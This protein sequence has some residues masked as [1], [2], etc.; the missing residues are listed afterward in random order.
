MVSSGSVTPDSSRPSTGGAGAATAS[1]AVPD[2]ARPRPAPT[3][4]SYSITVRLYARPD[5]TVVGR[6]ANTVSEANGMVTAVDVSE[7]RQD[8][9]TIDLTCSAVNGEHA[10]QIVAAM[11]AMDGVEVHRVSD[12]TF[13]LHLGGKIT[14]E[15]RV[16]LK[17]RDDL[18]MAYT[19]GVGRVSL[20]LAAHPEVRRCR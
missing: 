2:S 5:Y 6:L 20:A 9:I 10:E 18:S 14:V 8:R 7:S 17:T 1:G 13:L 3:S 16:P 11:R 15:S 4:A 12:R 19:P